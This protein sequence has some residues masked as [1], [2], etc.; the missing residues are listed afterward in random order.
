MLKPLSSGMTETML[1]NDEKFADMTSKQIIDSMSDE[2]QDALR[3]WYWYDWANQAYALTVMT[4]I[5]PALMASLYNT[6]TGTQGGAGF[7][8]LV[9][10]I[11]MAIVAVTVPALGVIADRMPIKK[12]MLYWYTV[13]GIIFCAGMGAAPYFGSKGY[14]VLAFMFAVGSIGFSGGNTI[15]YAFM[16]YLAP[17]KCMDHV[18]SWGYA[19][20]FLGGSLLLLAHLVILLASP[21]DT[22]FKMAVIFSTSAL[23]W[24]GWGA[25]MFIKTPEPKIL[26]EM[27]YQGFWESTKFAYT[28]VWKTLTSIR[29]EFPILFLFIIAYLLF[30][31][32]VNTINGMAT[33]FGESV[34]RIN[35][36][37]NVALILVVNFVAV[38]MSIVFAKVA[39]VKG[40]KYSLMI[41][42]TIY[43]LVA[44]TAVG[45]APLELGDDHE[46]YDFQYDW[47]ESTDN[48]TLSTLYDR[49]VNGWV[50]A[51][52]VG[53]ADFRD[54]FDTWITFE[55]SAEAD[56]GA[57]KWISGFGAIL[58]IG[59]ATAGVGFAMMVIIRRNQSG[60]SSLVNNFASIGAILAISVV[61]M[62]GTST[63]SEEVAAS[64]DSVY[65]LSGDDA[66]LMVASF[67]DVSN[68]R[69][70]IHFEGGPMDGSSEIGDRHPTML[71]QGGLFDW[72]PETM[73][74][75]VW[76]PLGISV[77]LQWIILGICVGTVMA[78]AGAQARSMFTLLI[79]RTRTTEFFGFFGFIG[80]AAAMVGP[81]LYAAAATSYDDRTALMTIVVVILVGFY[82]CA[83]VDL[84]KGAKMAE[85]YDAQ[86]G[87]SETNE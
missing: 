32:G 15:Y 6:A 80:K 67:D 70:S 65:M 54:A 25:L 5:V 59:V 76:A 13:V 61:V 82:L 30:Y 43:C 1:S 18:S 48:Y 50:S 64:E 45:F 85:D 37:M 46:R 12:K 17:K 16:P 39:E 2:D 84:E 40:T 10:G 56:A 29:A 27:E 22:N 51:E 68:H 87:K 35:P 24:W 69:F 86:Y 3:G 42:L 60:P 58:V 47:D 36:I 79:P 75:N 38:P 53:D 21:W 62:I 28:G 33:A 77:S 52:S 55:G 19:Y 20:G 49:G 14:L 9:Y 41:S 31:D 73:R 11:A 78:S 57:F 63:F 83:R 26:D 4:V 34:L 71:D 74:N 23:W 8:A 66:E 44:V 81:F 72:W 7:F